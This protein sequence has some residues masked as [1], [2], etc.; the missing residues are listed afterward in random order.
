M[1]KIDLKT[2]KP[3]QVEAYL[4]ESVRKIFG[5]EVEDSARIY[6]SHGYYDVEILIPNGGERARVWFQNFRKTDAGLIVKA[7]KTLKQ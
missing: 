2:A 6:S 7:M 1:A 3:R 5:N 4:R